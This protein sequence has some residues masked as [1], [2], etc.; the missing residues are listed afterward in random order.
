VLEVEVEGAVVVVGEVVAVA[1]GE[2][3][4]RVGGLEAVGVVHGDRPERPHRR[5]LAL[6]EVEQIVVVAGEW[7]AVDVGDVQRVDG[8]L[9][10]VGA[11]SGHG[12]DR[13]LEIEVAVDPHRVGVHLPAV[14]HL[15]TC[16]R[17]R[18]MRSSPA[19]GASSSAP[20]TAGSRAS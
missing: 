3:V 16:G 7:P 19:A 1:D 14:D 20:R 12:H 10:R 11:Q 9:G 17:V 8:V 5:Q 15:A 4:Q 13:A 18:R 6:V 2:A